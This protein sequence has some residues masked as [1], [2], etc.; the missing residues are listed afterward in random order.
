MILT[1]NTKIAQRAPDFIASFVR[2]ITMLITSKYSEHA[3]IGVLT[4][5][6]RF[7]WV[8]DGS[9][10]ASL[11]V[12]KHLLQMLSKP[13]CRQSHI[14]HSSSL[15]EDIL[16]VLVVMR[17]GGKHFFKKAGS[18]SP[19]VIFSFRFFTLYACNKVFMSTS[20]HNYLKQF[21]LFRT[22]YFAP[23]QFLGHMSK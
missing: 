18:G 7:I 13:Y 15:I 23:L 4:S 5:N 22:I 19:V 6:C 3:E 16:P 20:S 11:P 2:V 14:S 10:I 21:L 9:E 1:S 17:H 12:S 8:S